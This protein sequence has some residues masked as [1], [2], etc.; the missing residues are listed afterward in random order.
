MEPADEEQARF[1]TLALPVLI[2][3]YRLA[4]ALCADRPVA[5]DLLQ[6]TYLRA[7]RY[8]RTYQGGDFRAWLSAIMRNLHRE[9]MRARPPIVDLSA[10]ETHADPAPDPEQTAI[11]RHEDAVLR[12]HIAALPEVQ[13]E[14][15]HL[16]EFA[17]LSYAEIARIQNVPIGTVMSRLARARASLRGSLLP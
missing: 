9:E 17:E 13:R 11:R 8:F 7:M 1:R 15:L 10:L 2:P 4:R 5:D 3:L 12:H 16:R 6:E 14:A